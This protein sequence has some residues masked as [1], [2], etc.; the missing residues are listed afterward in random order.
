MLTGNVIREKYKNY[1]LTFRKT[2]KGG[3]EKW[4]QKTL[5]LQQCRKRRCEL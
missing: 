4:K 3:G 1:T 2:K 5:I